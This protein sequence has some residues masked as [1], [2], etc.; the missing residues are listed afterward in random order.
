[1][2]SGWSIDLPWESGTFSDRSLVIAFGHRHEVSCHRLLVSNLDAQ[3]CCNLDI[4]FGRSPSLA[5]L[6]FE[7]LVSDLALISPT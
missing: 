6:N 5:L 2:E 7:R 3:G 1:M 4:T